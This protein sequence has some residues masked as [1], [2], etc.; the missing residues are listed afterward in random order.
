MRTSRGRD[1][2]NVN[3]RAA[4]RAGFTLIELL[5]VIAII[6]VLIGLLLPAVQKVRQSAA[7]GSPTAVWAEGVEK[8]LLKLKASVDDG[9]AR[10]ARAKAGQEKIP[11]SY[12]H[13]LHPSML[14]AE[15]TVTHQIKDLEHLKLARSQ[16]IR[17]GAAAK[18]GSLSPAGT[19]HPPEIPQSLEDDLRKL[20]Q[21][22]VKARKL[23]ETNRVEQAPAPATM[24]K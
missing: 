7:K 22:L 20:Q 6:A 19:A 11:D 8:S 2:T 5:V 4:R 17:A 15:Q 14:E 1:R 24:A 13:S 21:E 23:L 9:Q 12:F 3:G 10:M 16:S 18:P